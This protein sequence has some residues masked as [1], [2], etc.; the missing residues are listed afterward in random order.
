MLEQSYHFDA[1][2]SYRHT[3]RDK[4][5]VD[6]VQKLTENYRSPC[7]GKHIKKGERI[8]RL[9]TDRSEL[10]MSADLGGSIKQALA[11]S[12]F[13]LVIASP[14]YTQ[15]R[16]CM[17]ELKTFLAYN[18]NSTDRILFIQVAGEPS[19]VTDILSAA[20]V[21]VEAETFQEPLYLDICA[22]NTKSSLKIIKKEYLRLAAVLIGCGFDALYQRH[23]R[24]RKNKLLLAALLT[25]LMAGTIG[26]LFAVKSYQ[27][28]READYRSM[29][30]SITEISGLLQAED[31]VDALQ[32]MQALYDRYAQN[33]AYADYLAQKLDSAAIQAAYVPAFSAF[34][35]EPLTSE[36]MS[37]LLSSDENYVIAFDVAAMRLDGQLRLS[38]YDAYL[39]KCSEH[40]LPVEEWKDELV[41]SHV[42]YKSL[43]IDYLEAEHTFVIEQR[44]P[45]AEGNEGRILTFSADG[46]LLSHREL[47]AQDTVQTSAELQ[48]LY[49]YLISVSD[50][51]I[52]MGT[53]CLYTVI[54]QGESDY[55]PFGP[56][57]EPYHLVSV[58]VPNGVEPM[59][60]L[61]RTSESHALDDVSPTSDGRF[62]LIKE[63]RG[64]YNDVLT[65]CDA[66]GQWQSVRIDL[67]GHTIQDMQYRFDAEKQEAIFLFNLSVAGEENSGLLAQCRLTDGQLL[68]CEMYDSSYAYDCLLS[69][70][71]YVYITDNGAIKAIATQNMCLPERMAG[72]D[73]AAP[74]RTDLAENALIENADTFSSTSTSGMQSV[75]VKKRIITPEVARLHHTTPAFYS[76]YDSGIGINDAA[77][78]EL[79][80]FFGIGSRHA[81]CNKQDCVFGLIDYTSPENSEVFR[82]YS[83]YDLM[84]LL[85]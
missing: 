39:N 69:K 80:Q 30:A 25:L 85:R 13:L 42:I 52:C 72:V 36:T 1:F 63:T 11:Q 68:N 38:L 73:S 48:D 58:S 12:R 5:I 54:T 37:I 55:E 62:V 61:E 19:C 15:S 66:E 78:N 16:W 43:R 40:T 51:P 10:P 32:A 60:T 64:V 22:P 67:G 46:Q 57:D 31:R 14:E 41:T 2:I 7:N 4:K 20:G 65:V 56:K 27:H 50:R 3:D 9:F 74:I 18:Q 84:E 23:K 17:E 71:G 6:T 49:A 33:G 70:Q 83:F 77:G 47:T 53:E 59:T 76:G 79:V 45:E 24:A 82:L 29:D 8:R 34:A 26:T 75:T 35:V 28:Q 44:S 21:C 81:Y